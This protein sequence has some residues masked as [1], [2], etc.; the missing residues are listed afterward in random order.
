MAFRRELRGRETFTSLSLSFSIR[1]RYTNS[2]HSLFPHSIP[3]LKHC[4]ACQFS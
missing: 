1:F 2:C 3:S 4:F